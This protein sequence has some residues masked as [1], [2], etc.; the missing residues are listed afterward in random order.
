MKTPRA[1]SSVNPGPYVVRFPQAFPAT[2]T[3]R[4]GQSSTHRWR[5]LD[6]KQLRPDGSFEDLETPE[7]GSFSSPGSGDPRLARPV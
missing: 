4:W 1:P 7:R 3:Q 6:R 5:I 2:A